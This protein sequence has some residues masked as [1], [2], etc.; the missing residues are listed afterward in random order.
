MPGT[1]NYTTGTILLFGLPTLDFVIHFIMDRIKASP[2]MLGRFTA[3][4]KEEMITL[5]EK[6]KHATKQIWESDLGGRIN[7]PLFE[8]ACKT[9]N[10]VESKK[11]SN[12]LFWWSLG[13]D[14]AVHHLTDILLIYFI[15]EYQ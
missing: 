1:L 10:E 8:S 14:Q 13:V 7:V 3:L 12:V 6:E 4:S 2:K 11:K 5:I 9:L 15:M